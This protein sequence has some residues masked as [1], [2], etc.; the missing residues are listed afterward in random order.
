MDYNNKLQVQS[1]PQNDDYLS[2]YE[3]SSA[4]FI[5]QLV[6]KYNGHKRILPFIREF[7]DN[8]QFSQS[9]QSMYDEAKRKY[10]IRDEDMDDFWT[11]A[12]LGA[13][14]KLKG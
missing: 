12:L 10:G 5:Q 6:N 11:N 9:G 13:E 8:A 3:K 2:N 14:S 4:D 7:R 1:L